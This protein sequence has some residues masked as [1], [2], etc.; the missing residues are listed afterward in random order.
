MVLLFVWVVTCHSL[1]VLT[2]FRA[3]G[4]IQPAFS[5]LSGFC[6]IALHHRAKGSL[7]CEILHFSLSMGDDQGF[8][9]RDARW[10]MMASA[11]RQR[12]AYRAVWRAYKTW[13]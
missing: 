6:V 13:C 12:R 9:P 8:I 2:T 11:P 10:R 3:Q 5:K 7:Y 4:G 1:H